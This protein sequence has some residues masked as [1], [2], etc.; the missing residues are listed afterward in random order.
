MQVQY[1]K[2]EIYEVGKRNTKNQEMI[3][4][5]RNTKTALPGAY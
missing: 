4:N 2:T 3:D 1:S 5:W